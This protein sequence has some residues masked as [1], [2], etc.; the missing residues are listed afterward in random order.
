MAER[1]MADEQHLAL[2]RRSVREWNRWR[3][4]NPQVTPELAGA[5]LRGL[6]FSGANLAG[7]E[8]KGADLRGTIL[9]GSSLAGAGLAG[10]NLFKAVL[11]SADRD[12]ADLRGVRFLDCAQLTSAHNWQ[13]A[14]RDADLECGV[15]IPQRPG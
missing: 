3:A 13:N 14:Y 5:G 11:D 10:A 9:S 7:A 1:A 12:G 15:P 6:D 8:L 2:L 4:E